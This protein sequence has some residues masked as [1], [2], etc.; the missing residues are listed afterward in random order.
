MNIKLRAAGDVA[1]AFA[2]VAA[3]V[4]LATY[5]PYGNTILA[6]GSIGLLAYVGWAIRVTML[7]IEN[8]DSQ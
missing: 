4:A 5:I 3:V 1:G 2:V 8:R 7:A 6:V